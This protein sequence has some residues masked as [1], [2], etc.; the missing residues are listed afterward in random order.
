MA[1]VK[2]KQI[3]FIFSA[4]ENIIY[5]ILEVPNIKNMKKK[6][7]RTQENILIF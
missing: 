3:C 7:L 1:I 5:G 4:D 6:N 2:V